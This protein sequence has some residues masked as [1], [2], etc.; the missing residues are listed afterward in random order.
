MGNFQSDSNNAAANDGRASSRAGLSAERAAYLLLLPTLAVLAGLAVFPTLYAMWQSLRIELIY[1]PAASR[2][3]GLQTYI[4]LFQDPFAIKA[5][6]ITALWVAAVL[7]VQLPV[8]LAIALLLDREIRSAW[9]LRTLIILPVFV[10][11]IAMGLTWRYLFEPVS[12][13]INWVLK[14]LGLGTSLWLSSP[15]TALVS[16]LI[17]DSWQWIPFV[18]VILLAGIQGIS[19]EVIEAAR[20]DGLKGLA[21]VRRMILPLIW[22]ILVVVVLIRM[23]DS[24]RA[25]DLFYIMTRGGP[26]SSTLVSGVYGFTMFETGR[27]SDMAALGIILLVVINVLATL[28][29]RILSRGE[30][31]KGAKP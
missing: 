31:S 20:L 12:G 23:V 7:V 4:G 8:G 6:G 2:F 25:F 5:F 15:N 26:G 11:P 27:L 24:I 19:T 16:V 22:P 1:N 30:K 21:F 28:A 18:A 13:V 10:S 9:L 3:V 14:S 17:A 29:L